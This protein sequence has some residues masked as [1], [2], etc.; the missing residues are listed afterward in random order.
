MNKM[1]NITRNSIDPAFKEVYQ[2]YDRYMKMINSTFKKHGVL[3]E[4]RAKNRPDGR[5]YAIYAKTGP[6][7]SRY[8]LITSGIMPGQCIEQFINYGLYAQV[9]VA[10]RVADALRELGCNL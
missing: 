7:D 5:V 2:N 9:G 8:K 6:Y 3:V 10:N 1:P 4:M